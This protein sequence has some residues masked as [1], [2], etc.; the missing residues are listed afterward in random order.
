MKIRDR[1]KELR[2]VPANQLQPHPLN[3]REHP[4][5][6]QQVLQG[7]LEEVGY[8]NALVARELEDG[9]LQLIDGHLRA[10]TTPD[11]HVPVLVLDVSESEAAKLLASLDPT[12]AMAEKND[13]VFNELRTRFEVKSPA[14]TSM[15]DDLSGTKETEDREKLDCLLAEAYSIWVDCTNEQQQQELYEQLIEQG[16]A[17]RVMVI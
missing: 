12:A 15:L 13:S 9:S 4:L 10:E 5:K 16:Y 7:I 17:C 2:R 14:L 3:W 8:A 11:E 1:I 6:Q